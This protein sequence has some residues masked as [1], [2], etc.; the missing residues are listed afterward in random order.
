M[1]KGACGRESS[2]S[3]SSDSISSMW[4]DAKVTSS[5]EGMEESESAEELLTG[6]ASKETSAGYVV[7]E[8]STITAGRSER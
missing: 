3:E 5:R 1:A 7:K 6:S 8:S 2:E 4:K